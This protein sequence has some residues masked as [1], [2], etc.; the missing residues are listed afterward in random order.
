MSC[1]TSKNALSWVSIIWEF[2]SILLREL[3][4]K[5]VTY[6][7]QK[8]KYKHFQINEEKV[9]AQYSGCVYNL[10]KLAHNLS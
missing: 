8:A 9:N 6:I 3:Q 5:H 2:I 4:F 7:H 10:Y 1:Q